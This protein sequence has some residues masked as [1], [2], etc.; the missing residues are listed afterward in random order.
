MNTKLYQFL[1]LR[2]LWHS[3]PSSGF[4]LKLPCFIRPSF[5]TSIAS[6]KVSCPF[7]RLKSQLRIH[8]NLLYIDVYFY[9]QVNRLYFISMFISTF[10]S[11]G[12]IL[13]ELCALEHAF[14]GKSLMAVMYKIVEGDPPDLPSKYSKELNKILKLWVCLWFSK[15]ETYLQYNI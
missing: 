2:C 4:I 14:N 15:H 11:I 12:C 9:F 5:Y 7:Y 3:K 13:Y 10:R 6:F 1:C 8:L